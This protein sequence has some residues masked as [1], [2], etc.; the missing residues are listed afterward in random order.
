MLS[1][2]GQVAISPLTKAGSMDFLVGSEKRGKVPY[3][4]ML[5]GDNYDQRLD[6]PSS[7]IL[8]GL[9]RLDT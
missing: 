5:R 1:A 4:L 8:G 2:G 6:S 7:P 9:L 3:D